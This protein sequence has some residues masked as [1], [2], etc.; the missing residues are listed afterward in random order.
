MSLYSFLTELKL[1]AM[2]GRKVLRLSFINHILSITLY[3]QKWVRNTFLRLA[4]KRK[5]KTCYG[6]FYI[7]HF[8]FLRQDIFIKLYDL[9]WLDVIEE[10]P[11]I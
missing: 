9:K 11:S 8:T 1:P 4:D 7:L 5:K 6:V 3:N 10:V 2:S